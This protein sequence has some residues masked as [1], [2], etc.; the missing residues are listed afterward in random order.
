MG[1]FL[2]TTKITKKMRE[3]KIAIFR[4]AFAFRVGGRDWSRTGHRHGHGPRGAGGD[5]GAVADVLRDYVYVGNVALH[6]PCTR[7]RR[8]TF[9]LLPFAF[10]LLISFSLLGWYN[11]ARFGS[12]LN[13]GYHFDSG[14]GFTT[15]ILQGLWGLLGNPY[16]G[17]F[18]HT[19]LFLASLWSPSSP[20]PAATGS[21]ASPSSP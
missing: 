2:F 20:S 6:R 3:E 16:R 17:V 9:C 13:T 18:W 8:T 5:L 19:P 14:E 11:A 15:P 1:S 21:K 7:L 10:C 12:F 4:S